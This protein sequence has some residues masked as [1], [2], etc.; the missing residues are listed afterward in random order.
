M[1]RFRMAGLLGLAMLIAVPGIAQKQLAGEWTGTLS[2]DNGDLQIL[3][4][5]AVAGDGTLT[6]TFDNPGEGIS[7]IKVKTLEL[8]DKAL[9]ITVDDQVEVNGSPVA[10]RGTFAGKLSADGNEISGQWT[11]TEPTE[12]PPMELKLKRADNGAAA[13]P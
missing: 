7:G 8:K 9:T 13:K 3:W 4:H 2:T 12:Q 5:A 1:I 10:L 6:S 11:Q